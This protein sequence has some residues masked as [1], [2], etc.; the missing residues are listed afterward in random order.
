MPKI[1]RA[2]G[3]THYGT[4]VKK[5][6]DPVLLRGDLIRICD[7]SIEFFASPGDLVPDL[8]I[9]RGADGLLVGGA[10][11]PDEWVFNASDYGLVVDGVTDNTTAINDTIDA[12]V[13]YAIAN[14]TYYA[15]VWLPVRADPYIIGGALISGGT[16]KGN[17]QIP[18]PIVA[19]TA[20]KLTLVIK[21]CVDA[22]A[23]PYWTQSVGQRWGV[24]LHTTA[25]GTNDSNWGIPSVI[26]GPAVTGALAEYG[27]AHSAT[28]N[29]LCVVVDGIGISTSTTNPTMGGFN[30]QG[31]AQCAVRR[32]AVTPYAA[33]SSIAGVT[34]SNDFSV[35]L[36]L[37]Q[38]NNNDRSVVEDVSIYGQY[39][40]LYAGEHSW[41]NRLA[42][43]YC[44]DGIVFPADQAGV[45]SQAMGSISIEGCVDAIR[46]YQDQRAPI[47]IASVSVESISGND[48][49]DPNDAL[50]GTI[51]Y[52]KISGSIAVTGGANVR[53]VSMNQARGSQ[54]P[55]SVPATTVPLTNPFWRDCDVLITGGTVSDIAIDG[56]STG[57]TSGWF[58]VPTGATITLTHT[59]AP[60]WAW[61]VR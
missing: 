57:L 12:A 42:C 28:F 21:G 8:R 51:N 37:P 33:T 52:N 4:T 20:R 22:A 26:G 47:N 36:A 11:A 53:L 1:S 31:L 54:T 5:S 9:Y 19:G 35:G 17:S 59:G 7:G 13:T 34:P 29:N 27:S 6:H 55:P 49:N 39:V 18:L 41:V 30:F 43:I 14:A 32:C 45:H 15:E 2:E 25:T 10:T 56:A 38:T 60:T 40:G 23:M 24:T 61:W 3:A 16:T 58:P 44:H 48:V 46:C 50:Y